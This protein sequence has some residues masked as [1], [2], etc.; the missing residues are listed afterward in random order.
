MKR[1]PN[2]QRYFSSNIEETNSKRFKDD[3]ATNRLNNNSDILSINNYTSSFTHLASGN[4]ITDEFAKSTK[5][6]FDFY[7]LNVQ[8][9]DCFRRKIQLKDALYHMFKHVFSYLG[10][11]I[12]GSSA[13]GFGTNQSDVD[14]CLVISHEELDQKH[15]AVYI[16]KMIAKGLRK[17]SFIRNL[18]VISAKVPI[19]KFHDTHNDIE[20]DINLNNHIGIR[21]THLLRCY[22]EQDW[23]VRPLVL[24]IKRWSDFHNI[25]DASQQTLSSYSL[26]LMAIHYLQFVCKPPVLPVLQKLFPDKF[27]IENDVSNLKLNEELPIFTSQNTQTLGELFSGYLDYFSNFNF[28]YSVISVRTGTHIPKNCLPRDILENDNYKFSQW[29]HILIEEPFDLSNTARSV[30][31]HYVFKQIVQVFKRSSKTIKETK[32]YDSLFNEKYY[33]P[34]SLT[35]DNSFNRR[36]GGGGGG[37]Y[38][39]DDYSSDDY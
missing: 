9:H 26:T 31:D 11:Y 39:R 20:C 3:S 10:V 15:E 14:I 28:E 33:K 1:A 37:G 6:I 22:S 30:F 35:L 29:K 16:L 5:S 17:A 8:S 18:S 7:N 2:S 21:N 13:N 24:S 34:S 4:K 23:R 32:S 38:K 19:I 27:N 12:V 36:G 25:N